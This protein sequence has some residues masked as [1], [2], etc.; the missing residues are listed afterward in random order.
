MKS[1]LT[2]KQFVVTL[3]LC[4]KT[5]LLIAQVPEFVKDFLPG[6]YELNPFFLANLNGTILISAGN[7]NDGRE[8]WKTDGTTEG[9]VLVKDINPGSNGSS[10]YFI[11]DLNGVVFFGATDSVNGTELWKTDGTT[12]GT[13]LVKD[14]Y[15]GATGSNPSIISKLNGIVLFKA[16]DISHETEI[17]KTDG[18]AAG[19]VLT[20]DICNFLGAGSSNPYFI[21]SINGIVL[22][23]AATVNN[24]IELWKT[25]GTTTGTVLVKDLFTGFLSSSPTFLKELN[26]I[27]LFTATNDAYGTELWRTDG[28][29]SGTILVKDINPGTGNSS[30]SFLTDLDGLIFLKATDATHG[31]E[32]WRTDGTAAGT[33]LI[34]DIN[35]GANSSNPGLIANFNGAVL[36]DAYELTHGREIW[37][38]DGTTAGTFLFADIQEGEGSSNP[39]FLGSLEGSVFIRADFNY[40]GIEFGFELLKIVYPDAWPIKVK[41]INPGYNSSVPYYIANRKGSI[42]FSAYEPVHGY[43]L[44]KTVD[45][46]SGAVLVK[47]FNPGPGDA[48]F[49]FVADLNGT[50]LFAIFEPTTGYEL[51]KILPPLT[52]QTVTGT[53][54]IIAPGGDLLVESGDMQLFTITPDSGFCVSE[55][56]V[57]GVSQGKIN[58]FA[59]NNVLTSH[60]ISAT[61]APSIIV[62]TDTD[63]DLYGNPSSTSTACAIEEGLVMDNTDCNDNNVSIHPGAPDLCNAVDDN[64]NGFTDE[65]SLI[66]SILPTGTVEI[67]K[68]TDITFTANTGTNFI[69]QWKKDGAIISNATGSNYTTGTKGDYTVT[70]FNE[71]N[72]NSTSSA[73]NLKTLSKP[74]AV[75][76][77]LSNLDICSAGSVVLQANSGSGQTYQ[78]KKNGSKING[79]TNQEF[80]ATVAANYK[81]VV[82]KINGC[83]KTSPETI[84]SKSCKLLD[85]TE[86]INAISIY[87]NPSKGKFVIRLKEEG[88]ETATIALMNAIGQRMMTEKTISINGCFLKEILFN[89]DTPDGIYFLTVTTGQHIY[90]AEIVLQR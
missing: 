17:W 82:T 10:P 41:D 75:I 77:P 34:K 35:P 18:T 25:D 58:T 63:N 57:D 65:N 60:T 52:I 26:G 72:C 81:V 7:S 56:I 1:L 42:L 31:T 23:G 39:L 67:C 84:V 66:A 73:T 83:T 44:W 14:I 37:K 54:G 59:F 61:F 55:V 12:A 80:T 76:T 32:L 45:T 24:G 88:Y 86:T 64:C 3:L 50:I 40:L 22:F 28:T 36:F 70:M 30:P 71:F 89:N 19:T 21:G 8:L 79:A 15:I 53:H 90:S 2:M 43:E 78:W 38:T 16:K 29:T 20:K 47:D 74:E 13:V 9:T 6:T 46:E 87:P 68:G 33:L 49:F 69:Y 62:Y 48:D 4:L 11:A 5:M 85:K 27:L 51:W